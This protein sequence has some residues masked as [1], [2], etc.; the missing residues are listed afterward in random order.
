MSPSREKNVVIYALLLVAVTL[1]FYNPIVRNQ[2]VDFDDLSYI[3]KNNH[4]VS[5]VSWTTVKWSSRPFVTE[6]GI[7]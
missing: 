2:F 4:V 5:G 3:V 1:F 6:T 7:P